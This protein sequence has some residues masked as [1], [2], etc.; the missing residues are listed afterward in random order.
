MM[1]VT[2]LTDLTSMRLGARSAPKTAVEVLARN[3]PVARGGDVDIVA[4]HAAAGAAGGGGGGRGK[5]ADDG[6]CE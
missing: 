3:H 4:V 1:A 5:A 2:S 6:E